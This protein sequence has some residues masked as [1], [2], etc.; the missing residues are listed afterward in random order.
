MRQAGVQY[1]REDF[2]WSTVE[3]T[4]GSF[5]WASTDVWMRAAAAAGIRVIA[6]PDS[7][8][9]WATPAWNVAPASGRALSGYTHFVR[10]VVARYGSAGAFWREN[11]SVPKLPIQ[12]VDVW[13]E[14]YDDQFWGGGLPNPAAYARMFKAVVAATRPIDPNARFML[15]ADITAYARGS[16]TPFLSAMF[17]AV[18][19]LT[20]YADVVS[21]HPY[22]SNGL[23]P[24]ACDRVHDVTARRFQS[25][26]LEDVVKTLDSHGARSTPVW[27]TE[28]GWSTASASKDGVSESTQANYVND[29]FGLLRGA[30]AGRVE[31]VVWYAYSTPERNPASRDDYFGLVHP[32]GAPKPAWVAL[33]AE[34]RRK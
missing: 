22:A 7:P 25:C 4:Q 13:N 12:F 34:T 26:R 33:S 6:V 11:P 21:V 2:T 23:S 29:V 32:G 20:K 14:P 31:G 30:W 5:C 17:A 16:Q 8:P 28:I 3:T 15:E 10:E 27:I 19:D 24:R 18:P 1:T 9:A